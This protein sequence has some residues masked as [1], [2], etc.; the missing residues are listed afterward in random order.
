MEK[1]V[2]TWDYRDNNELK[3][4]W[5]SDVHLGHKAC[6]KDMFTDTIKRIKDKNMPFADLGDLIENATK[7][8]VGAGVYEQSDIADKQIEEAVSLYTPVK[9]LLKSM[10]PGNHEARTYNTAGVNLTKIMARELSVPYGGIGTIH[11]IKVGDQTYIGYSTHGGSGATTIGGVVNAL[12]KLGQI[13]DA[14]F[15]IQGHTHQTVYQAREGFYLDPK[16]VLRKQ[17]RHFINNGSYLNY[18][19]T[20]AQ[21]KSYPVG[22]KGSAQLTFNGK[23]HEIEVSFV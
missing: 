3:T 23:K 2:I 5:I 17:R 1:K 20:Y 8:S 9:H 14:D 7:D 12:L 11:K 10:Q 4:Y 19:D 18:W 6:D 16:G 22:N 15:Y 13:V 21:A